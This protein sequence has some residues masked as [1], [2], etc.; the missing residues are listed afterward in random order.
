MEFVD[1]YNTKSG[2]K[3]RKITDLHKKSKGHYFGTAMCLGSSC[4]V[5]IQDALAN[6]TTDKH[7]TIVLLGKTPEEIAKKRSKMFANSDSTKQRLRDG[8]FGT[9]DAL[10]VTDG[11]LSKRPYL[12]CYNDNPDI[13]SAAVSFPVINESGIHA[14]PSAL[15]V[16][17]AQKY[18]CDVYLKNNENIVD[19]KSIMGVMTLVAEKDSKLVCAAH[20]TD[21]EGCVQ[22]A[23]ACIQD[24]TALV[25]SDKF[26]RE[27]D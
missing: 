17:T 6:L 5:E 26:V 1:V 25:K 19:G 10:C 8:F 22:D 27:Q 2:F 16:K 24:L 21:I 3:V 7:I 4:P 15:F 18:D 20:G 9:L 23:H 14:R 13:Q 12:V 11:F